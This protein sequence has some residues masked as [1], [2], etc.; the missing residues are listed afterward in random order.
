MDTYSDTN[1]LGDRVKTGMFEMMFKSPIDSN[2]SLEGFSKLCRNE[3]PFKSSSKFLVIFDLAE[4]C[5]KSSFYFN[6]SKN[7]EIDELS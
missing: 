4:K 7:S 1:L 2:F 3:T 5:L 6:F